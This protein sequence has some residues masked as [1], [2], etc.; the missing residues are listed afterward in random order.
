MKRLLSALLVL[1]PLTS[2]AQTCT[3]VRLNIGMNGTV[4]CGQIPCTQDSMATGYVPGSEFWVITDANV[5]QVA[6]PANNG[7]IKYDLL[8]IY[9]T[10]LDPSHWTYGATL[11]YSIRS[12][13]SQTA[14]TTPVLSWV[15]PGKGYVL[16]PYE[17]L[18]VRTAGI[19]AGDV[20]ALTAAGWRF[21]I[22]CLARW[23]Q[24]E[25]PVASGGTSAP[26]VDY[27]AF[28]A[29]LGQAATALQ[30]VAQAVP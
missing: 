28:V 2:Q 22:G 16:M 27:T 14:A 23:L 25:A 1:W 17:R 7:P 11:Q 20:F 30:G 19:P 3:P 12:V 13:Y 24:M 8:N 4:S 21:P 9:I 18:G 26:A 10:S 15:A 29:A 5:D 6:W